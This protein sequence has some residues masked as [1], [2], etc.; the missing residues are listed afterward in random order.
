[1]SE[2]NKYENH[3]PKPQIGLGT[4]LKFLFTGKF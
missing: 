1:M 4:M 2:L 3:I